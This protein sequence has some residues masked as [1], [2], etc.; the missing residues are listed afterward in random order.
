MGGD[1]IICYT[2]DGRAVAVPRAQVRPR[3]SVYGVAFTEDRGQVLLTRDRR[4][5]VWELPGG[6]VDPGERAAAAIVREFQEEVGLPVTVGPPIYFADAFFSPDPGAPPDPAAGGWY[7]LKL[8]YL[9]TAHGSLDPHYEESRAGGGANYGAAWV[10]IDELENV[11]MLAD[12]YDA[13]QR[14]VHW[15]DATEGPAAADDTDDDD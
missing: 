2:H 10:P 3:P 12:H 13:V 15:L 11:A 14:A 1:T 9:V 5:T 8:F 4:S 6:G 7:A